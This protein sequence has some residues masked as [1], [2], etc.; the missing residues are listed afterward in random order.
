[1]DLLTNNGYTWPGRFTPFDHQ[2]VTAEFLVRHP[3]GFCF[4]GLGSGKTLST[5]W[6]SDF[7]MAHGAI[8][9]VLIAAPLST[10]YS[11]WESDIWQNLFHRK[12]VV[13]YGSK[14]KRLELLK[15]DADYYIIN[16]SGAKVIFHELNARKDIDLVIL[17]ESAVVRNARTDQWKAFNALCGQGTSR[18]IWALTGEP[19]PTSPLDVWA[20]ARLVNPGNVTRYFTR[21]RE[22]VMVKVSMFKYAPVRGWQD[23][24]WAVLQPSIRFKTE[25]CISLPDVTTQRREVEM[26]KE[27]VKAYADMLRTLQ[28]ELQSGQIS[29]LNESAK[30]VKLLQISVGSIYDSSGQVHKLDIKPKLQELLSVVE[31]SGNKCIVFVNFRHS[32][33]VV[34]SYLESKGLSVDNV[35]GDTPVRTRQSIFTRFQS[36][37]LQVLLAHPQTLSHGLN[38]TASHVICWF[39][40]VDSFEHYGQACAR[41][42]RAGQKSKQIIVQLSCSELEKR[43]YKRLEQKQNSQGLLLELLE[44]M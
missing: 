26:S 21:F 20:Q 9:K 1:M 40:P 7:L 4:N 24:C 10:L 18:K 23:K 5:L 36:G 27:Q 37:D 30:R 31:Q 33:P 32:I 22:E 11:V 35:F 12:A 2:R 3:R 28:S 15:E 14:E 44:E 8:R 41:I 6:A 25:D 34:Q 42:R 16:H 29:A 13:L 38:L 43:V 19:M 39:G 17:D